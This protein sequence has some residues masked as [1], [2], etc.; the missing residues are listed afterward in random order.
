MKVLDNLK[1]EDNTNKVSSNISIQNHNNGVSKDDSTSKLSK[2][3]SE[4]KPEISD[5]NSRSSFYGQTPSK[6][7]ERKYSNS[8]KYN[9]GN[10]KFTY[11]NRN[12]FII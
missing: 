4:V 10:L 3:E 8:V 9:K 1:S 11:Y 6:K 7:S 12:S 2:E 5:N